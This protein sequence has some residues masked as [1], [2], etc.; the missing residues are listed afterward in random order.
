MVSFS[1]CLSVMKDLH[2]YKPLP[3]LPKSDFDEGIKSLIPENMNPLR[4]D[5]LQQDQWV[6]N[7]VDILKTRINTSNP[8]VWMGV[9]LIG[10]AKAAS[11]CYEADPTLTTIV[12]IFGCVIITTH[13][14]NILSSVAQDKF[15]VQP[16]RRRLINKAETLNQFERSQPLG[17]KQR[18]GQI[19]DKAV[20]RVKVKT[21]DM[22]SQRHR[23]KTKTE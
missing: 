16:V 17:L 6:V 10:C 12:E 19:K 21:H 15:Q 13:M 14:I 2:G 23:K 3:D 8:Q 20:R 11:A 18:A 22:L 9:C 1:N 5:V 4:E 7:A